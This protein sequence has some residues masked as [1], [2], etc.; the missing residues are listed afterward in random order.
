MTTT[1][2]T[3]GKKTGALRTETHQ[4]VGKKTGATRPFSAKQ[5]ARKM[6][7]RMEGGG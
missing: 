3:V 1:H 6:A 5:F 7:R 4:T 2:Q